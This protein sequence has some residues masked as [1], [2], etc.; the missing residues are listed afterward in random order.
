VGGALELKLRTTGNLRFADIH[1]NEFSFVY[2]E[3]GK[4]LDTRHRAPA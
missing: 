1:R 3:A 4:P 2:F